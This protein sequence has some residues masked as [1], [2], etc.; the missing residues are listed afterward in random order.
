[1]LLMA[2]GDLEYLGVGSSKLRSKP[3]DA[4][5]EPLEVGLVLTVVSFGMPLV[6]RLSGA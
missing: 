5:L 1:M 4:R 3:S 2:R 6:A